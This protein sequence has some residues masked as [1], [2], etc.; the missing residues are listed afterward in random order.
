MIKDHLLA[1]GLKPHTVEVTAPL[2]KAYRSAGQK[3][4]AELEEA[5]KKKK[6]KTDAERKVISITADIEK[7]QQKIKTTEKAVVLMVE[8]VTKCIELIK[9][10][11][12]QSS[13][14]TS[15]GLKGKRKNVNFCLTC[16]AII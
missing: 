12:D 14:K 11:R 6:K 10:K 3:S 15:N 1:N 9:K 8:K 5:K 4:M 2:I 13:V 16:I 7:I